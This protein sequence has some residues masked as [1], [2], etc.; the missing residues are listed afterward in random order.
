MSIKQATSFLKAPSS[1]IEEGPTHRYTLRGVA[2]D[3][4]TTYV[5]ANPNAVEDLVDLELEDWQWWKISFDPSDLPPIS[6][7]VSVPN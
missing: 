6:W 3:S 4:R 1:T 5:L 2:I 7:E